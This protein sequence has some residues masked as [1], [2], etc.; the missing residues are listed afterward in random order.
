M[1]HI[2]ETELAQSQCLLTFSRCSRNLEFPFDSGLGRGVVM[3]QQIPRA[4]RHPHHDVLLALDLLSLVCTL[5]LR[6]GVKTRFLVY[7]SN[8]SN[9]PHLSR[10][11]FRARGQETITPPGFHSSSSIANR[12]APPPP[13]PPPPHRNNQLFVHNQVP[14]NYAGSFNQSTLPG[15][16]HV[17]PSF[18]PPVSR[19]RPLVAP[20]VDATE[21]KSF[22][23]GPCSLTFDSKPA[24]DAHVS[25]HIACTACTFRASP[26]AVKA[27]HQA[28]HGKF[29][30][31]GFKTTVAVPGCPVQRFRICVGNRPEDIAAWIADRKRRFPRRSTIGT[32]AP[33]AD[34]DTV[35]SP[36]KSPTA[37]SPAPPVQGLSCLLDGYGSS[38]DEEAEEKMV[39][40]P[41][42]LTSIIHTDEMDM[43]A[44]TGA[45]LER[46]NDLNC[47]PLVTN[48]RTKRPCRFFARN[49]NCRNGESCSFSHDTANSRTL[50]E[51]PNRNGD[52][53]KS[54][55]RPSAPPSLLEKLLESDVR[56]E[57][58]LTIQLLEYIA[59]D[60]NF[61]S[62]SDDRPTR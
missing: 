41:P 43:D 16:N 11:G 38:S 19:K 28:A 30:G 25:S 8:Q 37:L 39:E 61:F 60:A 57:R 45:T 42:A 51:R 15:F 6:R 59:N 58:L 62:E 54:R 2:E 48:H 20:E 12:R 7:M 18:P 13:P 44:P 35:R 14:Y 23:C 10:L 29:A 55:G 40:E 33:L 24:L 31:S 17:Q 26:K 5:D 21:A 50:H 4:N 34:H 32:V 3:D 46:S 36:H 1:G 47:T 27:H 53:S 22:A 9:N 49:G 56:R 52:A